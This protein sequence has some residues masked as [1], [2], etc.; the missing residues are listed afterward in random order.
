MISFNPTYKRTS[1][2]PTYD[3]SRFYSLSRKVRCPL[4][5]KSGDGSR[6]YVW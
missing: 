2:K 4:H 3:E 5:F 1:S 6:T